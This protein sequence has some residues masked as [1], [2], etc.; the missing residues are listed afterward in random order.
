VVKPDTVMAVPIW[1]TPCATAG[2]RAAPR[3]F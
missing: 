3:R 1:L 2:I